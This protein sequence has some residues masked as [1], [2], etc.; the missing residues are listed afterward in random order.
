MTLFQ[1]ESSEPIVE[2]TNK[3]HF[4]AKGHKHTFK[5]SSTAERDNWVSQLKV[6][7]IEAKE[8]AT[9]ITESETYK[10]TLESFKPKKEETPVAAVAAEPTTTE[11]VATEETPA[12]GEAV[13]PVVPVVEEPK[14]EEVKKEEPKR[15]SA[16]RKRGSIFGTSL[17]GKKEEKPTEAAAETKAAETEVPA[18]ETAVV[19]AEDAPAAETTAVV[20]TEPAPEVTPAEV[21]VVVDETKAEEPKAEEKPVK[22]TATKRGSIFSNLSFGKKRA[23][24]PQP[25]AAPVEETPA[26]TTEA[27]AENAPVIPAVETTEPLS[28]EVSS[29][30]NVP[31]ETVDATPATNGE[32][33]A[34]KEVK[35]EKRKSSLPFGFGKKDK[36]T[37]SDD[38]EK[39]KSPSP[40]AKIRATIKS[41]ATPKAAEK[42]AETATEDKPV[43]AEPTT[44]EAIKEEETAPVAEPEVPVVEEAAPA[45]KPLAATPVISTAA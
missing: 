4:S 20:A 1:A 36:A 21:P 28:A 18:A 45:E 33:A 35:S 6:K 43:E 37:T 24:S 40:F 31:T 27:V 25:T 12:E 10:K 9:T 23:T 14:K 39:V 11:A 41:K 19:A 2:G 32:A 5:A 15:R 7:I 16:S 26:N 44:T 30:A 38:E 13:V 3:F 17:F 29:P 34:A 22:A 42:P 8:L